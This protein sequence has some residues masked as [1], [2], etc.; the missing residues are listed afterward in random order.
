MSASASFPMDASEVRKTSNSTLSVNINPYEADYGK[1]H[2]RMAA[3]LMKHAMSLM[4]SEGCF[5][6]HIQEGSASVM[7]IKVHRDGCEIKL[8]HCKLT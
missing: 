5:A 4:I 1:P 7:D 6:K 3:S 8:R 2:M